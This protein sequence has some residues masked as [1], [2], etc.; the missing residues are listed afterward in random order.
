MLKEGTYSLS[1]FTLYYWIGEGD[2]NIMEASPASS[3]MKPL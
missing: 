3:R 2:P 1:N